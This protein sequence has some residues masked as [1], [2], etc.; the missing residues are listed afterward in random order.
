MA[1]PTLPVAAPPLRPQQRGLL[2]SADVLPATF[3]DPPGSAEGTQD[4]GGGLPSHWIAGVGFIPEPAGHATAYSACGDATVAAPE[5]RLGQRLF[6][7]FNVDFADQCSTFGWQEAD[8]EG[9]ATRAL[10]VKESWRVEREFE[11]APQVPTNPHLA[12]ATSASLQILNGGAAT[13]ARYALELLT[14]A[15]ADADI[16]LGMVHAPAFLVDRWKTNYGLDL[17]G[18]KLVTASGNII[19]SGNGYQGVGPGARS[20]VDGV[21]TNGSA[22]VTSATAAFTQGDVGAT[23]S[24]AGIPASTTIASVQSAN[25]ITLSANATATATGVTLTIGATGGLLSATNT[26]VWAY[27]TEL[28]QLLQDRDIALLPGTMRE[29]TDRASNT[30]VYRASRYWSVL[31]GGLLHAAV[32]VSLPIATPA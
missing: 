19:V 13:E 28:V 30:V 29:A 23:I 3:A 1:G 32:K 25:S 24:G 18:G 5:L 20:P 21:T 15:I 26:T 9:R 10:A 12:D 16:G 27:A 17:V 14:Q 31:W 2:Q 4:A 8:Y 6:A 22:V 11:Q 7:P